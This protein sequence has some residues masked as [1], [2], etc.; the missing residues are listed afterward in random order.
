[1]KARPNCTAVH[2]KNSAH[3]GRTK[4]IFKIFSSITNE[5]LSSLWLMVFVNLKNVSCFLSRSSGIPTSF[6][7]IHPEGLPMAVLQVA[8]L[9]CKIMIKDITC[10]PVAIIMFCTVKYYVL[11]LCVPRFHVAGNVALLFQLALTPASCIALSVTG[12]QEALCL[13]QGHCDVCVLLLAQMLYVA[14]LFLNEN[15]G[16]GVIVKAKKHFCSLENSTEQGIF[17]RKGNVFFS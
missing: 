12:Q 3:L 17:Q 16:E 14:K 6:S 7:R 8:S 10:K 5:H 15:F 1:M 4:F 11:Y 2:L 9:H 13:A